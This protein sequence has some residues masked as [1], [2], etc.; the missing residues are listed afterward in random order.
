M[1]WPS[2]LGNR[3]SW[4]Q[5]MRVSSHYSGRKLPDTRPQGRVGCPGPR[6]S[7]HGGASKP[8]GYTRAAAPRQERADRALLG[9]PRTGLPSSGEDPILRGAGC[10]LHRPQDCFRQSQ[11]PHTASL[12]S[13]CR[14]LSTVL[15]SE[16]G[17]AQGPL[18]ATIAD[19]PAR[20]SCARPDTDIPTS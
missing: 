7:V 12:P 10:L 2:T 6:C 18:Q 15:S 14:L 4:W 20:V 9:S 19:Q 1:C 16:I 3:H 13:A 17:D 5:R 11:T 8:Q